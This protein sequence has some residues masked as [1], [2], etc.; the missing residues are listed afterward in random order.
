MER[1]RLKKSGG[2]TP[3]LKRAIPRLHGKREADGSIPGTLTCLAHNSVKEETFWKCSHKAKM[4]GSAG[5]ERL[6]VGGNGGSK[7]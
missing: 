3:R 5:T 4:R 1:S 7:T 6:R 2:V